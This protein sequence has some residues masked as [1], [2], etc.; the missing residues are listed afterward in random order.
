MHKSNGACVILSII[1]GLIILA[2]CFLQID[3]ASSEITAYQGAQAKSNQ[4]LANVKRKYQLN[5][6]KQERKAQLEVSTYPN[7]RVRDYYNDKADQMTSQRVV[8]K[9]FQTY[10][11]WDDSQ[12]Y[13]SRVNR[14]GNIITLELSMDKTVFDDAKDSTGHDYIKTSGLQ[15]EFVGAKVYSCLRDSN[16][17][18][19][20][21]TQVKQ[22]SKRNNSSE[23]ISEGYYELAINSKNQVSKLKLIK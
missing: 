8:N 2:I 18:L 23:G 6:Q 7:K 4:R 3:Y 12:E 5:Y 11:N 19:A 22:R 16:D 1:S 15:S 17:Q 20:V 9:F 13:K 10:L 21:L 14:L